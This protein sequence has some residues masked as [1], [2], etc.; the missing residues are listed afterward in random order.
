[1]RTTLKLWFLNNIKY[2][3]TLSRHFSKCFVKPDRNS[4]V[5]ACLYTPLFLIT[6]FYSIRTDLCFLTALGIKYALQFLPPSRKQQTHQLTDCSNIL[7]K[8]L[9]QSVSALTFIPHLHGTPSC[10][11]ERC[12]WLKKKKKQNT[13]KISQTLILL[14]PVK[15]LLSF[16]LDI[17]SCSYWPKKYENMCSNLT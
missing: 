14:H 13:K 10:V 7:T 9:F 8:Y 4:K 15:Y 2:C 11:A 3:I 1:M 12:L 17:L 16:T 5:I 6:S